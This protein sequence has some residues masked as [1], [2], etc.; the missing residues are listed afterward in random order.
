MTLV[1]CWIKE[2]C[3]DL[4][5]YDVLVLCWIKEA[6]VDSKM[7]F[8]GGVKFCQNTKRKLKNRGCERFKGFLEI[9]F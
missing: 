9:S 2:T 8:F 6:C 7:F 1:L 3:V 5:I 4:N